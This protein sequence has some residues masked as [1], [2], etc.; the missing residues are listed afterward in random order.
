MNIV[1]LIILSAMKI[2]Y[3]EYSYTNYSISYENLLIMNI[4]TL[5]I[6][7]AMKTSLL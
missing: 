7:S 5:I 4:V 1:T 3:Y 6:L 2:F